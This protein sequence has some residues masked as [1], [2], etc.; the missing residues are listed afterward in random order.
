MSGQEQNQTN[1]RFSCCQF[2]CSLERNFGCSFPL[3]HISAKRVK[4]TFCNM[5]NS[6]LCW[7]NNPSSSSP[8][9]CLLLPP[10]GVRSCVK[11]ISHCILQLSATE[12]CRIDM[13][14]HILHL[15]KRGIAEIFLSSGCPV[16]FLK[17]NMSF[18][19]SFVFVFLL[20]T[21]VP[22]SSIRICVAA[23]LQLAERLC[24]A[25]WMWALSMRLS[26]L[27]RG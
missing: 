7:R 4:M 25:V 5:P 23:E 6:F 12:S 15:D 13:R 17:S 19:L 27:A 20:L 8:C 9:Y 14:S 11:P 18:F 24:N 22:L 10:W 16:R 21:E 3:H 1:Y 2:F 26:E